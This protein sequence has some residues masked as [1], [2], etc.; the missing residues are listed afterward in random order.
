MTGQRRVCHARIKTRCFSS[1]SN[2][3]PLSIF[4]VQAAVGKYGFCGISMFLVLSTV[5]C[6]HIIL[7]GKREGKVGANKKQLGY[8]PLWVKISMV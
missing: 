1:F 3:F 8:V 2:S 5:T 6:F 7:V 4:L